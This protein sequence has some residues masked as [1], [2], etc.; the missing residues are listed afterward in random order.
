MD[1][2]QISTILGIIRYYSYVLLLVA[3]STLGIFVFGFGDA[4]QKILTVNNR[5]N[6]NNNTLSLQ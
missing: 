4:C 3:R 5:S 2:E 6:N 1:L